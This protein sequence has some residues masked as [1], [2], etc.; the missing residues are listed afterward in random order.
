MRLKK[1]LLILFAVLVVLALA[2]YF[3]SANDDKA[4]EDDDLTKEKIIDLIIDDV[5]A[6]TVVNGSETYVV[7]REK[8]GEDIWILTT[9]EDFSYESSEVRSIVYNIY[10]ITANRLVD[11]AATDFAQYGLD[12]PVTVKVETNSGAEHTLEIGNKTPTS[13]DRYARLN[14]SPKVYTIGSYVASKLVFDRDALRSTAIFTSDAE[15]IS[16]LVM[17]KNGIKTMEAAKDSNDSWQISYPVIARA[18]ADSITLVL[19]SIDIIS[20]VDFVKAD[21]EPEKDFGLDNPKYAIEFE[22][23]TE[24]GILYLGNEEGSCFYAKK[25]DS[26]DIFTVYSDYLDYV[27]KPIKEFV[28]GFVYLI[29]ID[30]VSAIDVIMDGYVLDIEMETGSEEAN[31]DKFYVNGR[32]ASMVDETDRQPFRQYY[33]GLIAIQQSDVIPDAV[34][35]GEAEIT[36]TFTLKSEPGVMK[37]EY[38]PKDDF[39]YYVNKNG[40][41]SGLIVSKSEFDKEGGLRQK[42]SELMEWLDKS[43]VPAG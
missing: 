27:D 34:A 33:E 16:K 28:D 31:N 11:D 12:K 35:V 10:S 1:G 40:K 5:K 37:I 20:V 39:N 24:K 29:N 18:D 25:S 42:Y 9:P 22:S 26:D 2:V 21:S 38:I 30:E 36:I 41:Y 14:G 8:A 4:G 7:E 19:E 13:D 23:D 3:I 15:E 17:Y 43:S 6:V 32:D